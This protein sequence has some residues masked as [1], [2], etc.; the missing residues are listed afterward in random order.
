MDIVP[1]S[2]NAHLL[3]SGNYKTVI[4]DDSPIFG[5]VA[6]EEI[7]RAGIWPTR[8]G[9]HFS[10]NVLV[11][12][13]TVVSGSIATGI[14]EIGSWFNEETDASYNFIIQDNNNSSKQWYV[15]AASLGLVTF[16]GNVITIAVHVADPIWK[17]VT[18]QSQNL[19]VTATGQGINL[20]VVGNRIARPIFTIT[21]TV[22]RTGGFAYKRYI[23][24]ANKTSRI[25]SDAI[26]LP[27]ANWDTASLIADNS[28]K[29][30][31]N[32][33]A[34]IDSVVT[35]IPYDTVTGAIPSA[36]TGYC[37]TEQITW[38]GKT[39]TT[40][41]NLTG[42]T[43][44]V[45]GT[46]AATHADNAE[47]K[48][49]YMLA[50][51]D[52][53]RVFNDETGLEEFRW[54]GGAGINTSTTRVF[55]NVT[56]PPKVETN[57]G[58][59]LNT[60]ISNVGSITT[61]TLK[62]SSVNKAFLT[63]LAL[64]SYKF[65]AIDMGGGSMEIFKFTGVNLANYQITGVTRAQ[66]NTS[67]QSHAVNATVRHIHGYYIMY[68]N[69]TMVTPSTDDGQKPMIDMTNST[70]SSHVYTDY[71]ELGNP[72]RRCQWIPQVLKNTGL[73]SEIYTANHYTKADTIA[74]E[75]GMAGNVYFVGT[76]IRS[77]TFSLAWMLYHPAGIT[78]ITLSGEKYRFSTGWP[79]KVAL[80]RSND[81]VN[82][83][84]AFNEATPTVVNTWEAFTTL[85]GAKALGATYLNVRIL[86]D[87]T[88]NALSGNYVAAETD[89][90]TAT[91]DSSNTPLILFSAVENNN[92]QE[93][94]LTN[95]VSSVVQWWMKVSAAM[96]LNAAIVIDSD[97][98]EAYAADGAPITFSLDDES[99]AEW[100]PLTPG[101][102]NVLTYDETGVNG[103]TV[104]IV[105]SDR[106]A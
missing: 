64:V 6:F 1:Y 85:N 78:T 27:D 28:N 43:R 16:N 51:G 39:G 4:S 7:E 25:Y 5:H 53:V 101:A 14:D 37:G 75:M 13:V 98:L 100:S 22:T 77:P 86:M 102:T 97:A 8:G 95:T 35:T 45:G 26:N 56:L 54:F 106:N 62:S 73:L 65:V 66:K 99:R 24:I 67:N 47:I 32:Q 72:N 96:P 76:V 68:G 2:F 69:N 55:S 87:G 60:A 90:V 36:G 30:Q 38:S 15:D 42:V 21:P 57:S 49:S 91:L 33:G 94:T 82:W 81:G 40:S 104:N 103:V 23:P 50:S 10:G 11:L 61:I 19:S 92:Y 31:I 63:A 105:W 18:P 44:G 70:N 88:I 83:V 29:M 17:V 71:S 84:T 89:A 52:D 59:G 80:Q 3:N 9:K 12:N 58:A 34:G 46:T 41:G 48:L 93:F 79:S 20:A 74:S